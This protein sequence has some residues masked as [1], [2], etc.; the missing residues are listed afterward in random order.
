MTEKGRVPIAIIV[1]VAFLSGIMFTTVGA[2][3]FNLGDNVGVESRAADGTAI[4]RGLPG[5]SDLEGAFTEVA[6][7]VNP[8][9]VQ[10]TAEKLVTRERGQ[11][12]NPFEGTP[13]EDFF[14]G[15]RGF[16][17]PEQ[18]MPQMGLGSG[19]I[20]RQDGYIL[21]NN[22]VIDGADELTVIMMNGGRFDAEVVGA[23][24]VSDVAVI[25]I[26]QDNL[27]FVSFGNSEEIRV[28]QWVMAFGSPL[29]ADLSNT[30]TAGII[31][32]TGRLQGGI[33]TGS[34]GQGPS[35]IHNFIQTDAAINRGNSGGPLVDLNGRLIGINTAIISQTGGNMGIGFAIPVNT[36][37]MVSDQLIESGQVNR[38]RLGVQFGPA[39]ES[40]IEALELP[41]GAAVI[42]Q[43]LP[44]SS[45]AQSGLQAGDI[46]ISVNGEELSNH[47]Q[48]SLLIGGMH[49]G[50]EVS[51][52]VVRDEDRRSFDVEL[53]GWDASEETASADNGERELS[54]R[55]QMMENLGFG[56]SDI[57]PEI[58]RRAGLAQGVSGVMVTEINPASEAYRDANLRQGHIIIEVD[59]QPVRNLNE[60]EDVYNDI[61]PGATFLIKMLVGEEQTSITALT[62]PE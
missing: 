52:T 61:E 10:I 23:D 40:L 1:V 43:V 55:D 33:G 42:S 9:V 46:I 56:L 49:P 7:R 44:G 15:P 2:N 8:T 50:D 12:R 19:V 3:I 28:G 21:T 13:F 16:E 20:I 41:R 36:V 53:G 62:K 45:A 6:E 18:P 14:G 60:F 4:D 32:A 22:H 57:T 35:Q 30:V 24:P 17:G 11:T 58:A 59:R 25:K 34:Q 31:S 51:L 29:S 26:N 27:P 54:G 38:A 48:L 47:L 39:S 5:A 37:E